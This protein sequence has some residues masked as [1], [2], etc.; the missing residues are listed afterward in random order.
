MATDEQT[1]KNIKRFNRLRVSFWIV[2]MFWVS[3]FAAPTYFPNMFALLF[4]LGSISGLVYLVT[5]G[6]LAG[7]ADKSVLLW[8]VG[9]MLFP[10]FGHITGYVRMRGIAISKGWF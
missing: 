3:L 1:V 7:Q 6:Q 5:I 10:L 8:V 2:C 9:T 4:L